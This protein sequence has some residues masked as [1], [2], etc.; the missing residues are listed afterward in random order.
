VSDPSDFPTAVV[1]GGRLRF[2]EYAFESYKRRLADLPVASRGSLHRSWHQQANAWA[3]DQGAGVI[4]PIDRAIDKA[5]RLRSLLDSVD[6]DI[7]AAGGEVAAACDA[8]CPV[9]LP[10][11]GELAERGQRRL[12]GRHDCAPQA[13]RSAPRARPDDDASGWPR[14]RTSRGSRRS[15]KPSKEDSDDSHA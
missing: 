14:R 13:P 1:F 4:V 10:D 8:I 9:E 5:L 7:R 11:A 12:G 3:P 15:Y 2:D 6:D